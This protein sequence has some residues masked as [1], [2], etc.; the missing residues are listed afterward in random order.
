MN[1]ITLILTIAILFGLTDFLTERFPR[2]Q[3]DI[4][5]LAW[6]VITFLFTIKY[7]YGADI[8][9]YVPFYEQIGPPRYVLAHPNDLPVDFE[10][11]YALFCSVLKYWGVSFYWHTAIISVFY[12]IVIG[13]LFR[14]IKRKRSFALAILVVMDYNCIFATYRQS[15]AIAFFVLMVL[16]LQDKKY[17]LAILL[18]VLTATFHKSGAFVASMV[19]FYYMVRGKW[20][21]PLVYQI[22][23]FVLFMV[24][25]LPIANIS[26]AF[27]EHLPLPESYI[28]SLQHHLGVGRQMQV[29][30]LVYAVTLVTINYFLRYKHSRM[31]AI[32]AAAIVGLAAV[33]LMYQYYYLLWRIRSYFLPIAIVY[34]FQLVQRV[35]DEKRTVPYGVMVKQ[36]ASVLVFLY[37]GYYT[38]SFHLHASQLKSPI[39]EA[40]TVFDLRH[41]RSVD[42]RNAQMKKAYKWWCEDF[43]SKK[44]NKLNRQ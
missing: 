24:F 40:C 17:I 42:I 26:F 22:I 10:I 39:Y 11:G 30:F 19:L 23:L 3:R 9:S 7:Y 6:L 44:N 37:L 5:Y 36:A 20:V 15:M 1:L 8:W 35:E 2:L 16:C 32:A 12:F 4:Y 28:D 31:E 25:L 21:Q 34:V 41:H 29:V 18:A 38:H 27:V 33:A 14:Q 13:I 43:E